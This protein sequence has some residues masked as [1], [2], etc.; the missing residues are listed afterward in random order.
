MLCAFS[1]VCAMYG[2]FY[3]VSLLSVMLYIMRCVFC[4]VCFM[5]SVISCVVCVVSFIHLICCVRELLMVFWM[6]HFCFSDLVF[7]HISYYLW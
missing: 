3:M 6:W 5:L 1:I 2:V 4:N 7:Y